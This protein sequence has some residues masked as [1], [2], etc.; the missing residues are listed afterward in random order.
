MSNIKTVPRKC[1]NVNDIS[2]NYL[3]KLVLYDN[4]QDPVDKK[5]KTCQNQIKKLK[6]DKKWLKYRKKEDNMDSIV[7]DEFINEIDAKLCVHNYYMNKLRHSSD[8]NKFN[9]KIA[10]KSNNISH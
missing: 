7:F 10:Q 8:K 3:E 4:Y 1:F 6:E 5:M 9:D 2:E